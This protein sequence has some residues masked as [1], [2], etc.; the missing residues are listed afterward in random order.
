MV[1][2]GNIGG[3]FAIDR[4]SGDLRIATMLDRETT[5]SYSLIIEIMDH[6]RPDTY[7]SLGMIEITVLDWNDNLP[8]FDQEQYF[9]HVSEEKPR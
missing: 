4:L 6:G 3:S 5:S 2:G 1:V 9:V 7:E 8:L